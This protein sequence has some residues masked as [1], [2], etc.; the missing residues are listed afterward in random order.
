MTITGPD[1]VKS[2][3]TNDYKINL[4][5]LNTQKSVS[6][7]LPDFTVKI[8][9][10]SG[11]IT[12]NTVVIKNGVGNVKL[13]T[14][15]PT[16]INVFNNEGKILT[17]KDIAID[18]K[19][20]PTFIVNAEDSYVG[21]DEIISS[22]LPADATGTVTYKLSDGKTITLNVGEKWKISSLIEGK[23]TVTAT[24]SGDSQYESVTNSTTFKILA[25]DI[26]LI[27]PEIDMYY[28]D[29][30][31][32]KAT[33]TKN[34]VAIVGA[35]ITFTINGQN[36]QRQTDENGIASMTLNL[37]SGNYLITT[38]YQD[39]KVKSYATIKSTIYGKDIEKIYKNGT[40]YYAKF[41]NKEGN[42]LVNSE[43]TFNINGVFYTRTTD[44]NGI[45]K[46]SIN[47]QEGTYILTATNPANE[48]QSSN[49]IIVKSSIKGKDIRKYYKNGTQYE[50][51]FYNS[52]GSLL[53]N[54][55]VTFNIN[56]V[57]YTRTTNNEGVAKLSINL[58]TGNYILTAINPINEE[59]SSNNINILPLIYAND[60]T[61]NY[62]DGS[63]FEA[64]LVDKT[65]KPISGETIT[66]NV[67]GVFYYKTTDS[68]G[69]AR[70]T[71]NLERGEYIIT[72]NHNDFETSNKI[73]IK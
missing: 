27:V 28:K 14:K 5:T 46:L 67:N 57:F 73:L 9:T 11:T 6:G 53:K 29:G 2:G 1:K 4:N 42:P 38:S 17:S 68:Q 41:L 39:I 70:L 24:Y 44:N 33:L 43:I 22:T 10:T 34:G 56:G 71:I 65:G 63:K 54:T 40:Q 60:L 20:Q 12:P 51:T 50:A 30:T 49:N 48:E 26:K 19:I 59:Q 36:Y 31:K 7:Y 13:T 15:N 47:L 18:G 72:S 37:R 32:L 35:T 23:Y 8:T 45:A 64:K 16:T 58:N 52:D 25:S 66:F 61:M 62:K 21:Y 55:A 3:S 69:V